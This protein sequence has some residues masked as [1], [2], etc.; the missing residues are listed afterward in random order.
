VT[1]A[2][3]LEQAAEK[4]ASF[5]TL[6]AQVARLEARRKAARARIDA[7]IDPKLA[8]LVE[9]LRPLSVD[10][11]S[12]WAGAGE[13]IRKGKKSIEL[14]GC[15]IGTRSGSATLAG[16][17]DLKPAIASL[18]RRKWGKLL[19]RTKHE[20]DKALI[21]SALGGPNKKALAG[22]GFSVVTPSYFFIETS[23][24]AT[25]GADTRSTSAQ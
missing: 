12:W 1:Q 8:P 11:K 6:D 5:A 20:I 9:Q 10:L 25:L 2:L 16:P 17:E 4:A 21:K 14:S 13:D 23:A 15:T 18:L 7:R 22:M 19:L 3:T 24:P